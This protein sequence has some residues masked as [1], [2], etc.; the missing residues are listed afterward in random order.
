M[1]V[2]LKAPEDDEVTIEVHGAAL[3]FRDVLLA[4]G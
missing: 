3:N 4:M 2:P 1:N